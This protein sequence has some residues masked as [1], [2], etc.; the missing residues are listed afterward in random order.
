M[1]EKRSNEEIRQAVRKQYGEAITSTSG[2]C[3]SGNLK[4]TENATSEMTKLAGYNQSELSNV[5]GEVTSFGCGNPIAFMELQPGE[6]VLDLGS[7]AG[8]DLILASRKVGPNGKVIGLDMTP[9]MIETSRRNLAAA[10]VTNAEVRQ[11]EMEQMPLRDEEVDWI[12]SNCVINLSPEKDKVFAEAF[13]VLKPGG[14]ILVS[15]IVASDLPEAIRNDLL[16]WVGCIAG[17]IGEEEY[18][19]LVKDAGF[20]DVRIVDRLDYTSESLKTLAGD[21]SGCGCGSSLPEKLISQNA[22]RIASVRLHA[23]KPR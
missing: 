1:S 16:S 3:G 12:M 4:L 19:Q 14:R 17:A 8:L 11:G 23:R 9:E 15:D 18:V 6:V 22:G 2:C 20:E 7:G 13:R 10:G 5:A 21:A